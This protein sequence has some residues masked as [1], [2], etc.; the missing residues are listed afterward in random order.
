[1]PADTH[2]QAAGSITPPLHCGVLQAQG[3]GL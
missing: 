2:A 1:V 3:N